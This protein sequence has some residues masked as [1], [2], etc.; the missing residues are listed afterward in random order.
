[1][2]PR[3][4]MTSFD[5]WKS[6]HVTNASDDLLAELLEQDWLSRSPFNQTVQLLRQLP[7]DFD[8]APKRIIEA[9]AQFQP[10]IIL[11][12]GMAEKRP[13]LTV[14][15][16]AKRDDQV[17][18]TSV[19][20]RS[21]LRPLRSTTISYDAGKFVCNHT[22]YAVLEYLQT[23]RINSHCLFVHVPVLQETNRDAIVEDF[24]AMTHAL[25]T[26]VNTLALP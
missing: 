8:L 12:C 7:V 18:Q 16:N 19:D 3:I 5:I 9:I 15:L 10:D 13:C 2:T 20:L 11:C 6:H 23:H 25:T 21:L 26:Q 24:I 22:Y 17:L 1:M 14:E 4:L